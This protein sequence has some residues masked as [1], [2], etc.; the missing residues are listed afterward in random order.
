MFT[1][2][3][4]AK[5]AASVLVAQKDKV[6][7][8]L[9]AAAN[10]L[11]LKAIEQIGLQA[12]MQL[13]SSAQD[14]LRGLQDAGGGMSTTP[15]GEVIV[16]LVGTVPNAMEQGFDAFDIKPG[17]LGSPKVKHGK[18]GKPYIDVPFRWGRPGAKTV[19]AM[20]KA[21]SSAM[22]KAM[23]AAKKS[24]GAGPAAMAL[25]RSKYV[26]GP[27]KGKTVN[28][29]GKTVLHAHKADI[30]AGMSRLP[31]L[32]VGAS[33]EFRTFR[34][35]SGSSSVASWRHPGRT[36]VEIFKMVVGVLESVKD[37]YVKMQ[38]EKVGISVKGG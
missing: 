28:I 37:E 32:S 23:R 22:D 27:P 36:G 5:L 33:G 17:L 1:L 12:Q 10:D 8:A 20:S 2:D 38:L 3:L 19:Q 11:G 15:S 25:I 4:D 21:A 6:Q 30:E 13:K 7:A 24:M 34:R 18:S 9:M 16:T 29:G 26:G 31:K 35:V 14:Y